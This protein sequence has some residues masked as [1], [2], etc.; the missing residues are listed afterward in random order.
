MTNTADWPRPKENITSLIVT[1]KIADDLF[2]GTTDTISIGFGLP[3]GG[4]RELFSGPSRG[5]KVDL[6]I[7]LDSTS[8]K[9]AISLADLTDV[10]L[11]QHPRPHPIASDDWKLESLVLTANGKYKNYAFQNINKWLKNP[12]SS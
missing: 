1:A 10:S 11:Y 8:G 5:A 3:R 9:S 6:P 4:R 2:A 12:V 7:H